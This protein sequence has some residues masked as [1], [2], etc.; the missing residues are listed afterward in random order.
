MA[1]KEL[2]IEQRD[3]LLK[4]LQD[5][6]AKNMHRH[7]GIEWEDVQSRLLVNPGKLWTLNEMERT[8]G[9]PDV[10]GYD[11]ERDEY[12]FCDCSRESPKGR[13]SVCYD[14]EALEKRKK[15]KPETS[16]MD[17]A[18]EMG[19]EILTEEQYR[20]LQEL[21]EFDLKTSSWI[22]TP[23]EI[24]KLGGALFCDRRYNHVFVYHNGADSYYGSRGFRGMMRV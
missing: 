8:G 19:I 22:K 15:H 16:A 23:A 18:Q 13:R 1:N 7:E 9:E 24:R 12:V 14:R 4:V 10:V 6:F 11:E 17:M 2:S 3:K 21:D 20:A 5:R